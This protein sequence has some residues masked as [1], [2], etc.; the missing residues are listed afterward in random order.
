MKNFAEK[1]ESEKRPH[2]ADVLGKEQARRKGAIYKR[3]GLA[4]WT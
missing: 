4:T 3:K 2:Q 1:V